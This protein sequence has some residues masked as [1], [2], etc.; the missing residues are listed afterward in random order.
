MQIAPVLLI[1]A[2]INPKCFLP[3]KMLFKDTFSNIC[4]AFI[5][6]DLECFGN[7]NQFQL[8]VSD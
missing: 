8:R 1:F 6:S 2:R 4:F 3:K 5:V 7:E